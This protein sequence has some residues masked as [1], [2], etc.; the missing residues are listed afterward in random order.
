MK[1]YRPLIVHLVS[2]GFLLLLIID[3]KR[4]NVEPCDD[5]RQAM[6]DFVVRISETA[7]TQ[8]PDFVVIPQNDIELATLL[9]KV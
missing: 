1:P 2:F 6:R 8:D 3:C 9:S 7:R 5:Y 4:P